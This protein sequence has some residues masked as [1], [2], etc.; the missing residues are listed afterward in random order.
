M[1]IVVGKVVNMQLDKADFEPLV[2]VSPD[3]LSAVDSAVDMHNT[4][5]KPPVVLWSLEPRSANQTRLMEVLWA[6]KARSLV[7]ISLT[8][9]QYYLVL[10][11]EYFNVYNMQC[12]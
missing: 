5:S 2:S 10:F 1:D 3:I 6:T 11:S 8:Y 12:K 7:L 9:S 4:L